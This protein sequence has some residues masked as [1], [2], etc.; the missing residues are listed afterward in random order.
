MIVF[1]IPNRKAYMFALP[2]AEKETYTREGI[3]LS[4]FETRQRKRE[5]RCFQRWK[6]LDVSLKLET[7]SFLTFYV[8][9]LL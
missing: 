9:F 4:F 2:Y 8:Y 7:V 3:L 1:S 5:E 6:W